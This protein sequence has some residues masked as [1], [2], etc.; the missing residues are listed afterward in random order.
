MNPSGFQGGLD[1]V[2]AHEWLSIIERVF[3]L[4]CCT[5]ENKLVFSSYMIEGSTARWWESVLTLMTNQGVPRD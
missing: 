3:Q 4:V 2:K 1:L 5:K